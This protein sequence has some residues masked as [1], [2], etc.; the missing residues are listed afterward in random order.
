MDLC[1]FSNLPHS[2][3]RVDSADFAFSF[4]PPQASNAKRTRVARRARSARWLVRSTSPPPIFV[5]VLNASLPN[6]GSLQ[7][8]SFPPSLPSFPISP[9][10]PLI[11][12][13]RS[14]RSSLQHAFHF[15]CIN[16]WLK[17][18]Q[19]CPLDNR[20]VPLFLIPLSPPAFRPLTSILPCREWELQKYGK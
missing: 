11:R 18:R 12:R 2:L 6:R 5:V 3:N 17:T 1:A 4:L 7:R 16:R 15:H 13:S 14:R 20:C 10:S 8:S 19:V 9:L